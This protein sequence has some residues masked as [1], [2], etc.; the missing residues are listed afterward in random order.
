MRI[1]RVAAAASLTSVAVDGTLACVRSGGFIPWKEL[2]PFLSATAIAIFAGYL[3]SWWS[4][5]KPLAGKLRLS[6]TAW[7]FAAAVGHVAII[8]GIAM[9]RW[10][11]RMSSPV[12]LVWALAGGCLLGGIAYLVLARRSL[13]TTPRH[14]GRLWSLGVGACLMAVILSPLASP[15]ETAR[16]PR[17]TTRHAIPR[18]ILITVDTLRADALSSYAPEAPPTPHLD[19][20]TRNGFH[21]AQARA[22]ST[23]T[24]TSMSTILTGVSPLVLENLRINSALPTALTTLAERMSA[25]GYLTAAIGE[26]PVLAPRAG[27][28]RGFDLYKFFP[29][30]VPNP[31]LGWLLLRV[32]KPES[33]IFDSAS[34]EAH[35]DRDSVD[36]ET[37][38]RRLLSMASLL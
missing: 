26:N 6:I 16:D 15:T 30:Q 38:G 19:T 25:A 11:G 28:D 24:L 2:A 23:W 34:R 31:P 13:D 32:L 9:L 21:F 20:F 27:L 33:V 37:P 17:Q 18:V 10:N 14:S 1:W 36:G 12:E 4:L 35:P 8:P 29:S 22:P 7:A 3:V 5:L